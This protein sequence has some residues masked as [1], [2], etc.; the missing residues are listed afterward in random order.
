MALTKNQ[1]SQ[2]IE[3]ISQ[4][5]IQMTPAHDV[6]DLLKKMASLNI[7]QYPHGFSYI[8][9]R[10]FAPP[11]FHGSNSIQSETSVLINGRPAGTINIAVLDK[12]AIE[13][14]EVL[15]GPSAARYGANTMGG[16]VNIITRKSKDAIA[17]QVQL[18]HGS[19]ASTDLNAHVGGNITPALD[20]D[21]SASFFNR[22]RDF[23][24]GK[25]NV[26]RNA[27]GWDNSVVTA[28]DQST[29][30]TPDRVY[31]GLTRPF[32]Q[33]QH[34]ATTVRIGYQM[35]KNWR[36]DAMNQRFATTKLFTIGDMRTINRDQGERG[37][38]T[39][40]IALTGQAG[41]HS[42]LV[43]GYITHD[44]VKTF[45]FFNPST[46]QE[47]P[48]FQSY[49]SRV[50]YQGVQVQDDVKLSEQV[51]LAFGADYYQAGTKLRNWNAPTAASGNI[52]TER[53]ATSPNGLIKDLGVFAQAH[54]SFLQ[55]R[56]LVNPSFRTD[57]VNYSMLRTFGLEDKTV[58]TSENKVIHSP[59]LG[60]LVNLTQA[61][62]LHANVGTAFRYAV[63]NQ[64]AGYFE[65]FTA[66]NPA[67]INVTLGNPNLTNE[68]SLT[69]ETGL[70]VGQAKKGYYLDATFFNTRVQ[71]RIVTVSDASK[72]NTDWTALDGNTYKI[73]S[74][75]TFVNA[76]YAQFSGLE[77][78]GYYD[79]G[80]KKEFK[81]SYRFFFNATKMF[82]YDDYFKSTSPGTPDTK[83]KARQVANLTVGGGFEYD[84]MKHLTLRISGRYTGAREYVNFNDVV[85]PV[86]FRNQLVT[87]P[88]HLT[89][90][91]VASYRLNAH[92]SIALRIQNV[93]DENFYEIRYQPMPG[94]NGSLRYTFHF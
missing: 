65:T 73:A 38:E 53:P 85:S 15:K 63:A 17:G 89:V 36:V 56:L 76:N 51:R 58:L 23:K 88:P 6:A 19:W 1:V 46:G 70:R 54:L 75:R 33:M 61:L 78:E 47:F 68:N 8:N 94:R 34:Y 81:K 72:L 66:T 83:S 77:M 52:P 67:R 14:I 26:L 10:G 59:N 44:L 86:K 45:P 27:F 28:T 35:S 5:D 69:W 49:E 62:A 21:V 55:N 64:V 93:T 84:D 24:I 39:S 40:E 90:D 9:L 48:P 41:L 31:D 12:N 71:D 18:G 43:K 42:L 4:R 30:E 92:H 3:L 2:R 87:Y 60:V 91:L 74:Y 13:R 57:F 11:T 20:F 29:L 32:T 82:V 16:V 37:Y 79:L 80:A 25:G 22:G 7:V 50:N